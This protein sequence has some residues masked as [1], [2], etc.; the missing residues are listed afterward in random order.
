MSHTPFTSIFQNNPCNI[1]V[2]PPKFLL[3]Y[4][5]TGSFSLP[6]LPLPALSLTPST[7]CPLPSGIS[8]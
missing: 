8:P 2:L 6:D 7:R 5:A 3:R 1:S 4:N